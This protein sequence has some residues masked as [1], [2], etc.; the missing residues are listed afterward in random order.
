MH[1][2]NSISGNTLLK[3]S[4]PMAETL[5]QMLDNDQTQDISHSETLSKGTF[6]LYRRGGKRVFDIV[7]SLILLPL[8]LFVMAA[9]WV[10]IRRDGGAAC[11]TQARVGRNGKV[12]KCYKFRSMVLGAERVL[13]EM[14]ANDPLVALEWNTHQKLR[15]DPRI[16]KVG[17]FLRKTSL[18]ELPQIFNVL[19]GDMSLVGPRP[20]MPSQQAIYDA[21]GGKAYYTLRPGVTGLWQ[22]VSRQDTTF[23]ARVHFDESYSQNL[24]LGGDLSLIMRTASVVISH[25]GA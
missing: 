23:K 4:D 1:D 18:D 15:K 2:L 20:F 13:E 11:F 9:A 10:A 5:A 6:P 17:A 19:R 22:I 7:F 24:S 14:C 21:A 3:V 8:L 16:T 12:F 25:T